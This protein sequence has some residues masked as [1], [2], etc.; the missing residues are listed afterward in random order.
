MGRLSRGYFR[1]VERKL[2]SRD[3]IEVMNLLW[4]ACVLL[5]GAALASVMLWLNIEIAPAFVISV[6]AG[7]G[8]GVIRKSYDE[9]KNLKRR[10]DGGH[11][12]R[13]H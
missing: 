9:Y 8:L 4:L 12:R 1:T 13:R 11:G 2:I 10:V 6:I 7:I 5:I 3:R